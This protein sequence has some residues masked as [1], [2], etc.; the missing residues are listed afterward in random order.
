MNCPRCTTTLEKQELKEPKITIEIDQ[1][2][3][4]KGA[5]FDRGE[6]Q[7][8]EQ[9]VEPVFL[10]IRKI[11]SEYDQLTPLFCPSC[12]DHPMMEK[13]DHPR[14][15]KVILDVCRQCQGIWLDTGELEAIQKESWWR[16]VLGLL[17]KL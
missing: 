10:E 17:F 3:N 12:T 6:L 11:P 4:C 16:S 13:F 8:V 9:T 7:S 1:C 14:D 15:R 5:W 2:P